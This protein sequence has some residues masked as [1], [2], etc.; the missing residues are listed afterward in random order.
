M[1]QRVRRV[2]ALLSGVLLFAG[3]SGD[4]WY[5]PRS[6]E[7]SNGNGLWG[8]GD[9]DGD[10][11]SDATEG[12]EDVDTDGDGTPDYLDTDSDNDGTPDSEEGTGDDDGD[13]IPNWI[14]EDD[15]TPPGDDDDTGDDDDD[16]S[17]DD[18]DTGD[19]DDDT[20]GD[21]DDTG[22]DDDD[23][24]GDDDDT[25]GDDDDTIGDDDDT[26]GDD[27]DST[28]GDDDDSVG[29]AVLSM[30]AS[31]TEFGT[32][33]PGTQGIAT[34][35]LENTGGTGAFVNLTLSIS[36]IGPDLIWEITGGA[37]ILT[38]PPTS[39]R[40]RFVQFTPPAGQP[41]AAYSTV[42][43]AEDTDTGDIMSL[44]FTADT[45]AAGESECDDTIDNDGDLLTDC[46]DP[47]CG[48]DP[49]CNPTIDFCC[50]GGGGPATSGQCQQPSFVSCVCAADSWCCDAAGGWDQGCVD[51]YVLCGAV[52]N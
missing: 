14:D 8:V 12:G 15:E 6:I 40:T 52:C 49:V 28:V 19:D 21:D 35:T 43:E 18:D 26:T 32:V 16:T 2:L 22:D 39:T 47:D 48:A 45:G 13:G 3:C 44:T 38:V 7:L 50:V 9:S 10:G 17:G 5:T 41:A 34:V 24:S 29:P 37:A 11:I 51:N 23:T 30:T 31:V 27:D 4:G 46:D 1:A 25:T 20:S 42:L 33:S 36:A